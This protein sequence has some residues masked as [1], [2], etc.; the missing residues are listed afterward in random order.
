MLWTLIDLVTTG[1]I[2][3]SRWTTRE[4]TERTIKCNHWEFTSRRLSLVHSQKP[5][6]SKELRRQ[7]KQPLSSQEH[8]GAHLPYYL[9]ISPLRPLRAME[10]GRR[11]SLENF[12]YRQIRLAG[13][14]IT[15]LKQK[16]CLGSNATWWLTRE[17]KSGCL[18]SCPVPSSYLCHSNQVT[19]LLYVCFLICKMKVR[20]DL[21]SV[22]LWSL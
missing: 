16:T 1:I 11:K 4:A 9:L 22:L 10:T 7:Q 5:L 14:L 18:T 19:N 2:F 20:K 13:F 12:Q 15:A 8:E 17:Q 21:C 6:S 3:L